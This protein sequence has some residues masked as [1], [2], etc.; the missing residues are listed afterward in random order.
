MISA[1]SYTHLG[2]GS[3]RTYN[4]QWIS[5]AVLQEGRSGNAGIHIQ[6]Q[7]SGIIYIAWIKEPLT[8]NIYNPADGA[9]AGNIRR[10]HLSLHRFHSLKVKQHSIIDALHINRRTYN[11]FKLTAEFAKIAGV[12]AIL[13][14]VRRRSIAKT[15]HIVLPP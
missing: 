12:A 7:I 11:I 6:I 15:T 9:P 8:A 2:K 3:V 4:F 13:I 10:E 5:L 14:E 1:V